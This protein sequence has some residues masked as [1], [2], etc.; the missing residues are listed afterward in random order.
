MAIKVKKGTF[1]VPAATGALEVATGLGADVKLL[2]LWGAPGTVEGFQAHNRGFHS[3]LTGTGTE[4]VCLAWASDD[5]VTPANV[6]RRLAEQAISLLSNGTPTLDAEAAFTSFGTGADSGKFT[7]NVTDAPA[8]SFTVH[9]LAVGGD[10]LLNA[11]VLKKNISTGTGTEAET[12]AG[13]QPTHAIAIP[14]STGSG[15][16]VPAAKRRC[17]TSAS[18]RPT[19]PPSSAPP[20]PRTTRAPPPTRTS[21]TSRRS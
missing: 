7:L 14:T 9:Y 19:A 11:K 16:A 18:A 4:Q 13:F 15:A 5:A 20:S 8:A 3:F 17:S 10:G 21:R 12:G 2:I 1:T 6:G